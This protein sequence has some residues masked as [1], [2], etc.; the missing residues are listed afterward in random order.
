MKSTKSMRSN[1]K[2]I[3]GNGMLPA[4]TC[5]VSATMDFS[6]INAA[7]IPEFPAAQAG[8]TTHDQRQGGAGQN[9]NHERT[10]P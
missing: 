3:D 2:R 7:D 9:H 6:G 4:L 1:S 8:E 10:E 5:S